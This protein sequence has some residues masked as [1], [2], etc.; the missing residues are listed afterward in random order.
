MNASRAQLL[1][2]KQNMAQVNAADLHGRPTGNYRQMGTVTVK[3][4]LR[5]SPQTRFILT[6][7]LRSRT[8][9]MPSS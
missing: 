2:A 6:Y 8:C 9:R 3:V 5:H 7:I 1:R 4:S